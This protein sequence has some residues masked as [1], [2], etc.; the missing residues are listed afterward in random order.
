MLKYGGFLGA[1]SG[2]PVSAAREWIRANR[3]LFRL[4]DQAVTDLELLSDGT[5][6]YSAAHAALFRQRFGSRNI[7]IG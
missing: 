3:V 1:G 5:M 7:G 2:G 4:S 6:P